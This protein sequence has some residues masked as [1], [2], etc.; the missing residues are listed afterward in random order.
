MSYA[1]FGARLDGEHDDTDA[2]IACHEYANAHGCPVYQ[3]KGTVRMKTARLM[4]EPDK[5]RKKS[6]KQ[7]FRRRQEERWLRI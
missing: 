2:V 6:L 5:R 1:D 4:G 3:H 7:A